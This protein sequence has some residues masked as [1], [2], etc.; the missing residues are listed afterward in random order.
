MTTIVELLMERDGLVDTEA[1]EVAQEI[2]AR[3]IAGEPI[4]DILP[5]YG[6]DPRELGL[7]PVNFGL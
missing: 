4:N 5:D 1:Q 2:Y 7:Q 6:I 3:H